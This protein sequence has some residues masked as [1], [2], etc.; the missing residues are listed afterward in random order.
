MI[1]DKIISLVSKV[2]E[3]IEEEKKS[4]KLKPGKM[5][6]LSMFRHAHENSHSDVLRYLLDPKEDH[7]HK[8]E[9]LKLFLEEIGFPKLSYN[10]NLFEIRR[11]YSTK[12][13]RRIDIFI[14]INHNTCIIIENKVWAKDQYQQLLDY[15][16]DM[17]GKEFTNI[18][19][20]YLT[21]SGYKASE[22]SLGK[23]DVLNE[24]KKKAY[25]E[26]EKLEKEGK[27]LNISY[28][29]HILRWLKQLSFK[30]DEHTLRSAIEQYIYN[31]KILTN[32]T[33]E[34]T[35]MKHEIFK[36]TKD[37][38]IEDNLTECINLR[39]V[40]NYYIISNTIRNIHKKLESITIL[41][42]HKFIYTINNE[43]VCN[44]EEEMY[45][46]MLDN[47]VGYLGAGIQIL[48]NLSVVIEKC[49]VWGKRDEYNIGLMTHG[50]DKIPLTAEMKSFINTKKKSDTGWWNDSELWYFGKTFK[51]NIKDIDCI[52]N[53]QELYDFVKYLKK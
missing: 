40:L 37:L 12:Q 46:Y 34:D 29:Y 15:C 50:K 7:K 25:D 18:H 28:G 20:L 14:K 35:N 47:H 1:D 51:E 26:M 39:N 17:I 23:K 27:F 49:N 48:D 33:E 3:L 22:W 19:I 4:T 13:G 43:F 16:Q 32:Q 45:K 11:E 41:P 31:I 42:N 8:D 36:I 44:N 24:E 5:S 9:Y 38:K 30:S 6:L 2:N 53:I 52:Q 21:L 10:E